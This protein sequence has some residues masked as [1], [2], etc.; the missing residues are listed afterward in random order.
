MNTKKGYSQDVLLG[1][2]VL[3]GLVLAFLAVFFI[4]K[5]KR[6]FDRRVTIETTFSNVAGLAIGAD[7]LL[8]G[9]VIGS[10]NKINFPNIEL[11]QSNSKDVTVILDISKK[12]I[13]WI[14]EDSIARID[15]KGLL[16]DK[17]VNITIG[18]YESP[19]ILPEG[20]VKSLP[21]V[22]F[23]KAL[24]K[25]QDILDNVSET[26]TDVRD[27][28]KS[29]MQNGGEDSLIAS[30][31]SLQSIL[32]EVQSGQGVISS[33][34]Y[35]KQAG[36]DAKDSIKSFSAM[37]KEIKEGNGLI[38]SVIYEQKGKEIVYNV[39]NLLTEIKTGNGILHDL[40]Y[41][42]DKGQFIRNLNDATADIKNMAQEVASGKGSLGLLIK[43]P[44]VYN[45][46]Y[47]FLGDLNRNRILKSVVRFVISKEDK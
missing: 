43:D 6:L 2:F 37:M 32:K 38:N 15:S 20:R 34:I 21:S 41:S 14:R 30:V 16:G 46:L 27:V 17:I 23:N 31:K 12:S 47:G 22:D 10:V 26:V 35:D 11:M 8:S 40:I 13:K 33:L 44:S 19:Q 24:L 25:A 45:E 29:F 4:G 39:S 18:S 9:V 3:L 7:V 36:S 5:E 1:L 28:F 42:T